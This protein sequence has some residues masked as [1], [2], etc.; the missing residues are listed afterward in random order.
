MAVIVTKNDS[1]V[2]DFSETVDITEA[3]IA[4]LSVP[5]TASATPAEAPTATR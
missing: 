4:E 5:Q 1:V 3:V 2:Y